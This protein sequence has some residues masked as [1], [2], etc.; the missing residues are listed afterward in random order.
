MNCNVQA[1]L[2]QVHLAITE[3]RIDSQ[4]RV[5]L[6]ELRE[7]WKYDVETEAHRK[8]EPQTPLWLDSAARNEPLGRLQLR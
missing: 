4:L 8:N 6:D 5:Q 1:L 7:E 2:H 3:L